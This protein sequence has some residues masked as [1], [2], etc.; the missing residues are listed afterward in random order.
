MRVLT[1]DDMLVEREHVEMQIKGGSVFIHPTDTIYGIGCDATNN[2]AVQKIR[3]IKDRNE[4]PFSVIAPSKE[5]IKENCEV[6]KEG[7]EWLEKLPGPYTLILKLKNKSAIAKQ[8]NMGMDSVGVRIPNHWISQVAQEMDLPL[9]TTS[10]NKTGGNFMTSV[11]DLHHD[12]KANVDFV[13]YEGEKKGKPSTIVHLEGE[14]VKV[15]E[16]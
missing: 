6:P 13:V 14:E 3:K 2:D 11:D 9:V 4:R 8:V 16:R 15:K 5:W 1:K 12:I 7:E 10:A